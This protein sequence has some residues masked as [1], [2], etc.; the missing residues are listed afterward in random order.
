MVDCLL[1]PSCYGNLRLPKFSSKDKRSLG[2]SRSDPNRNS[3]I[4]TSKHTDSCASVWTIVRR[5]NDLIRLNQL[6]CSCGHSFDRDGCDD[7]FFF[8]SLRQE[9]DKLSEFSCHYCKL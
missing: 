3:F 8:F 2:K 7:F 5:S 6:R 1:W 4:D 9:S